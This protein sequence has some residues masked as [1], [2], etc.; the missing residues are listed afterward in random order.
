M[1]F[2]ILL[3]ILISAI[4]AQAQN[5]SKKYEYIQPVS[6]PIQLSGTFAE[7]RADH[8]HSGIDIRIGGVEGEPILAVADGYINRIFVSPSGFGKALY[9][10]HPENGHV[11]VYGHLQRFEN[12]ISKFV[13]NQQYKAESFAVNLFPEAQQFIV[14]KGDIIAY[15]GN[16]GSSGGP[17]LHFEIRDAATQEIL[18]PMAVGFNIK[19]FT[20]P[21]IKRL[22]V[23]PGE[24]MGRVNGAALPMY[25]DVE[26]KNDV[27]QIKSNAPVMASG[28]ISFGITASDL[29]N[30]STN[31][32]GIYAIELFIDSIQVFGFKADRFSFDETRYVNSFIDYSFFTTNKSRIVRTAIDPF[33]LLSMY[34][35]RKSNGVFIAQEGKRYKA[36]YIVSDFNGN[37]SKLLFSIY[38][39]KAANSE[40]ILAEAQLPNAIAGKSLAIQTENY[41]ATFPTDAFYRNETI[42]HSSRSDQNY[43][44]DIVTVG[45]KQIPVHK[46]FKLS[47]KPNLTTVANEKLVIVYLDNGAL[48]TAVGGKFANGMLEV[49]TRSLGRFAILADLEKPTIK[50]L[51]FS[52]GA[53]VDAQKTLRLA[54]SDNLSGIDLIKP[55]L[56]GKWLL[57]DYDP[58]NKLLLY[59][60]DERLIAGANQFKLTVTDKCGNSVTFN[61]TIYNNV[62]RH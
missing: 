44:S 27:Y 54:I 32:N 38:G 55:S 58:K 29:Q 4:S 8:F 9:V 47:I 57:M 45:N 49:S 50:P 62:K 52:N 60:I 41:S 12:S 56:N 37:K 15:G 26:L 5:V 17:H 35:N 2:N 6:L 42:N 34:A 18:N 53:T 16:S 59:E 28:P 22:A 25:C 19:D 61:A 14:K 36:E 48:P 1:K 23:Y 30:D 40:K 11:S 20:R 51:N 43:L 39:Q 10:L 21:T 31:E 7:L 33:N 24:K 46:A 3:I 13:K